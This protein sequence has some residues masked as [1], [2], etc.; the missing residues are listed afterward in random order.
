MTVQLHRLEYQEA[1]QEEDPPRGAAQVIWDAT[2][3]ML[4]LALVCVVVGLVIVGILQLLS[5]LGRLL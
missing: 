3:T 2:M 1:G 5:Q 4:A